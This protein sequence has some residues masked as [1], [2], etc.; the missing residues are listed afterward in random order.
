MIIYLRKLEWFKIS[1]NEAWE[2][3]LFPQPQDPPHALM[4]KFIIAVKHN[5][6]SKVLAI[7]QKDKYVVYHFDAVR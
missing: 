2:N 1:I 4:H 3:K 5:D 7:L 6:R